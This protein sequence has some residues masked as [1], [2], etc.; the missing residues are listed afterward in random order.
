MPSPVSTIQ[1]HAATTPEHLAA[2]RALFAE[3][4]STLPESAQRS[5]RHQGFDAELANLPG[6]YAPPGGIILLAHATPPDSP[7]TYLGVVALRPLDPSGILPG[8]PTPICEMKRLYVRPAA[9]GL[10]AGR[11][12]CEHLLAAAKAAG[13]RMMKLDTESDF[14][15]ATTLYRSL[16]FTDIPRYNDDPE[17]CTLW[18]GRVL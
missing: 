14:I 11:L 18:M 8:D 12:L 6:K 7:P 4:A 17:A 1:V 10:K 5:L 2:A 13:Y 16:G 3:Y 15:A 9:R